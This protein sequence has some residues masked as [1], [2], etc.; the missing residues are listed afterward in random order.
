MIPIYIY[1]I[2]LLHLI[3]IY[4]IY[5][6]KH[7]CIRQILFEY[8]IVLNSWKCYKMD[9]IILNI[10]NHYSKAL[11]QNT[12]WIIEMMNTFILLSSLQNTLGKLLQFI[13]SNQTLLYL[14]V[15]FNVLCIYFPLLIYFLNR[16]FQTPH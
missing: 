3:H 8:M 12:I 2:Y 4:I 14:Y 10:L 13:A 15:H 1:C 7:I 6:V 9:C 16:S 11:K 5:I